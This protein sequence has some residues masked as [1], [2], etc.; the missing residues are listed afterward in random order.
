[1]KTNGEHVLCLLLCSVLFA[2]HV[3]S[4]NIHGRVWG[5]DPL[6]YVSFMPRGSYAILGGLLILL[7]FALP[8][9]S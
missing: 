9:I 1:M 4:T 7:T 2:A 5:L 8:R 6:R 3:M